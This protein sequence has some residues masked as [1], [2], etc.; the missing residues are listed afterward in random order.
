[1]II[2][3][4]SLILL[5]LTTAKAEW[6]PDLPWSEL[7][8]ATDGDLIDTTPSIYLEECAPEF[9]KLPGDFADPTSTFDRSNHGLVDQP[10]G[11]CLPHF[12]CSFEGC[13]PSNPDNPGHVSVLDDIINAYSVPGPTPYSQMNATILSWV[14]DT[15]NP[16]YNLPS[17][18]LLPTT[19][20]DVVAAV[21]FA[22]EHGL[23]LSVK[24][25]GHSYTSA[26]SKR[27]TL[28]LNM[29]R[30]T[31]YTTEEGV[32]DC[33]ALNTVGTDGDQSLNRQPCNLALAKGKDAVI[34]VGGGENWGEVYAAVRTA[35]EEQPDGYK[36][37]VIGGAAATVSPMVR[38][39]PWC[40]NLQNHTDCSNRLSYFVILRH[41]V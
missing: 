39:V 5:F 40:N 22:K 25:S 21:K 2:S 7:S 31:M 17:K 24:N 36:Y 19:A 41:F 32:T 18:V 29:A 10:S 1:M 15:S 20:K 6:R 13:S 34:R 12:F 23:E 8:A 38:G 14:E 28:L 27:D 37:H 11:L 30:Y 16:S 9:E 26:S 35:N 4:L 3:S 33:S